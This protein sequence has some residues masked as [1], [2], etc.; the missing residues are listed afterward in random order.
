MHSECI[1]TETRMFD[2]RTTDKPFKTEEETK[3]VSQISNLVIPQNPFVKE[4]PMDKDSFFACYHDVMTTYERDEL[5]G[6]PKDT[7]IYFAGDIPQRQVHYKVLAP[8]N[9]ILDD[10]EGYYKLTIDDHILYRY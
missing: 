9:R 5:Q 2:S 4:L 3:I 6:M 8:V 1:I 10:E 7:V